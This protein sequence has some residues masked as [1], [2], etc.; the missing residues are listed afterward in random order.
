MEKFLKVFWKY[1][2]IT[3][4]IAY[5]GFFLLLIL[6]I[7]ASIAT[8]L[9]DKEALVDPVTINRI[10]LIAIMLSLPSLFD[11]LTEIVPKKSNDRFRKAKLEGQCPKCFEKVT[12]YYKEEQ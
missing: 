9:T 12:Y 3:F 2:R 8:T 1:I 10:S 11:T 5:I 6:I 4:L 7:G